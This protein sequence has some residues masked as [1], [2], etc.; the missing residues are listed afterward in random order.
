MSSPADDHSGETSPVE[1]FSIGKELLIGQI[2]DSN[3]FWLSQQVTRLGGT[4]QR[5]S[6]LDDD[7]PAIVHALE[8]AIA[9]GAQTILT[10]GGLGPT[11]DDLTVASI[12]QLAGVG[13]H[14]DDA[15]VQDHLRRR[16]ISIDEHTE[17]LKRMATIP[18]GAAAYASPAG[19]APLV[20]T[21]VNGCTILSMPGPPREM[22]AVFARFLE[23]YFSKGEGTHRALTHRV[24]VDMW[25]SEV[26]PMLQQVMEA[27]PGTY[28]KGYIALGNQRF[29]P[30]D[31]V[32][33]GADD[34]EAQANL[35]TALDMLERLVGEAERDFQR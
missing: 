14:I 11:P 17:N 27:V 10:T 23:E 26:A 35:N 2:Q 13:T 18:D 5:V 25:E 20:R 32:T 9:R 4:M 19:W 1:I 28:C 29:L 6:I 22:E 15:V 33:R 34:D 8:D 16:G 30:I 21:V 7:Q 3:S 31:V 24:Y 12:A